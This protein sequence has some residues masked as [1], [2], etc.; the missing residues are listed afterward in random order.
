MMISH[1]GLLHRNLVRFVRT[2]EIFIFHLK[3]NEKIDIIR[4][5]EGTV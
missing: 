4:Q 3:S 5:L 2:Y 1:S